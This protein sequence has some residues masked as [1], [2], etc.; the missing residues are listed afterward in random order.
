MLLNC[1]QPMQHP[2]HQQRSSH[3]SCVPD[4]AAAQ[5]SVPDEGQAWPIQALYS[6]VVANSRQLQEMFSE[7][8]IGPVEENEALYMQLHCQDFVTDA[9]RPVVLTRDRPGPVQRSTD[10]HHDLPGCGLDRFMAQN[11]A[12]GCCYEKGRFPCCFL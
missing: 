4:D 10:L 9:H 5:G 6:F 8:L 11:T 7:V 1:D 3:L 12:L 2:S